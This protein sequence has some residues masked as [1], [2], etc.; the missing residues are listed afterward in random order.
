M[1][2][3][4]RFWPIAAYRDCSLR[5]LCILAG[6]DEF[7]GNASRQWHSELEIAAIVRRIDLV[8]DAVGLQADEQGVPL[9]EVGES[10]SCS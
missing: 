9:V 2:A 8:F 6:D 1:V 4:R 5:G 10:S 3:D 7:N